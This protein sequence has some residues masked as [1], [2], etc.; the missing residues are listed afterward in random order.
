[1]LRRGLAASLVCL[2]CIFVVTARAA[3]PE[4]FLDVHPPSGWKF[5]AA[6]GPHAPGLPGGVDY[7]GRIDA[8]GPSTDSQAIDSDT[9]SIDV[10]AVRLKDAKKASREARRYA[11]SLAPRGTAGSPRPKRVAME[12]DID[13]KKGTLL[14]IYETPY[15]ASTLSTVVYVSTAYVSNGK[16]S[17]IAVRAVVR[18][19]IEKNGAI[20]RIRALLKRARFEVRPSS[21]GSDKSNKSI[22]QRRPDF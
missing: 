13:G 4:P 11:E 17:L 20:E 16:Q 15:G 5:V 3:N 19:G 7:Q 9:Y 1:M 8:S 18:G 6:Q 22:N 12:T 14:R 21:S 10:H 2:A